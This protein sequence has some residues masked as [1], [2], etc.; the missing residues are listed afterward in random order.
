M[1]HDNYLETLSRIRCVL[2][3]KGVFL[4]LPHLKKYVEEYTSGRMRPHFPMPAI[5]L[6]VQIYDLCVDIFDDSNNGMTFYKGEGPD[7]TNWNIY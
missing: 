7:E 4:S 6:Y 1:S 2:E 3:P 5:R